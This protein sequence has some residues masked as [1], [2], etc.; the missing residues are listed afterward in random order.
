MEKLTGFCVL[1][2]ALSLAVTED[3]VTF[4]TEGDALD[5]DVR[6]SNLEP[7]KNILWKFNGNLL[8][9]WIKDKVPVE[10]YRSFKGRSTLDTKNGRLVVNSM[11]QADRGVYSVEINSNVQSVSYTAKWIKIVP[12]PEAGLKPLVCTSSSKECNV[13][14]DGDTKDAEPITYHWKMGAKDWKLLGKSIAINHIKNAYDK[15]F[16]CRMTNPLSEK[17]SETIINP[18]YLED[19]PEPVSVVG[20]VLGVLFLLLAL[21]VG[22]GVGMWKYERCPFQN[23]GSHRTDTED[24]AID[25]ATDL[26]ERSRLNGEE[27][28]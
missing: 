9:E 2:A 1:L 6:P 15:N 27:P 8:A 26:P 25:K 28:A 4:F 10:F 23:R 12:Q 3:N 13:S 17:V 7:I 22:V 11:S 20:I 19:E 14:C 24:K 16:T 18:F 5:L 21:G